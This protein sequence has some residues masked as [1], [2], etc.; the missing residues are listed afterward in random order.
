VTRILF[1]SLQQKG[2]AREHLTR[3]FFRRWQYF[4]V[5]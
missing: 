2:F 4:E 5:P 3:F 1:H